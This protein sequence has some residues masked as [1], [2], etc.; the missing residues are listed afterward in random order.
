MTAG[1]AAGAGMQVVDVQPAREPHAFHLRVA[2]RFR[3]RNQ[4]L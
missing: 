2:E 1:L 4:L 3:E